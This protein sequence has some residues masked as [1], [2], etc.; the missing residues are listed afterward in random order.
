MITKD[1]HGLEDSIYYTYIQGG[2]EMYKTKVF[3]SGNSQAIRIP[4][5]YRIDNNEV[6]INKIGDM[7][8]IAPITALS[9]IF[10]AGVSMITDDFLKDGLP[11]S[12]SVEREDL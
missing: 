11:E 12:I 5:E 3:Q 2:S 10:D 1:I 6:Y 8:L 9:D 7:I 4:K